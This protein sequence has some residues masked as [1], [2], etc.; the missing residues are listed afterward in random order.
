MEQIGNGQA[1][2]ELGKIRISEN[3]VATIAHIAVSRIKGVTINSNNLVRDLYETFGQKNMTKGIEIRTNEDS[4]KII[5]SLTVNY[6]VHI[7][8]V[9]GTVQEYV[10]TQVEDMTGITVASVDVYVQGVY[11]S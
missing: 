8:Q 5:I 7:P 6:G 2:T 9:A 4:T 11:M 1:T 10:Q 3:V